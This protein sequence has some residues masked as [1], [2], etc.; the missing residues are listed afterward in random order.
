MVKFE[1]IY[2]FLMLYESINI[3]PLET[4]I[5]VILF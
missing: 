3:L 4:A 2:I 1:N 5:L